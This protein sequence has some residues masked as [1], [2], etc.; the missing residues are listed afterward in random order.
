MRKIVVTNT[1]TVSVA[2]IRVE[3]PADAAT[4]LIDDRDP[5]IDLLHPGERD[6]IAIL[7]PGGMMGSD[8]RSDRVRIHGIAGDGEPVETSVLVSTY[9]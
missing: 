4:G 8:G 1:G 2:N 7:R 6:N 3:L 5:A 9:D